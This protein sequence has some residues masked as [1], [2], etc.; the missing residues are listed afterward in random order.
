[1]AT[2]EAAR[3]GADWYVTSL[4]PDVCKT[5]PNGTPIPYQIIGFLNKKS[6]QSKDVKFTSKPAMTANSR[7]TKV[8]GN[9]PGTLGGVKSGVNRNH[10]RPIS[11]SSSVKVNNNYL[12]YKDG[13]KMHMNCAG[14]EGP[15]NTI[16]KLRWTGASAS[17]PPI[18]NRKVKGSPPVFAETK[19]E[20]SF[21]GGLSLS[22]KFQQLAGIAPQMLQT[23]W[24][25]PSSIL[26]AL[27]GVANL[28]G[29][30]SLSKYA[31]MAKQAQQFANTNW[32]NPNSWLTAVGSVSG[33][34]GFQAR[35]VAAQWGGELSGV[36]STDFK[37]P[38]S[39]LQTA[40]NISGIIGINIGKAGTEANLINQVISSGSPVLSS[41]T[42]TLWKP[43]DY[44]E[45]KSSVSTIVENGQ[46]IGEGSPKILPENN[47]EMKHG[48]N[49]VLFRKVETD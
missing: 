1:M 39:I 37:N 4:F 16:G 6:R 44:I 3:A 23:N 38:G 28:G 47:T 33:L 41:L 40:Q 32:S 45:E 48:I 5:P 42:Q 14:P 36:L 19:K 27:P 22:D 30:Q 11:H 9:E 43:S 8:I 35:Q 2:N 24:N 15:S 12:L 49:R 7:V 13:T 25:N 18:K 10:C 46:I 29:I 26:G 20:K 34:T 31:N 21:L 17:V